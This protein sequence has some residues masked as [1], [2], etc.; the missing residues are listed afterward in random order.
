MSSRAAT[1]LAKDSWNLSATISISGSS[2]S[3]LPLLLS[4]E[5]FVYLVLLSQQLCLLAFTRHAIESSN[6]LF[7]FVAARHHHKRSS[8]SRSDKLSMRR[9]TLSSLCR[10]LSFISSSPAITPCCNLNAVPDKI[11]PIK[12]NPINATRL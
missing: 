6:M 2:R 12:K 9:S 10:S 3:S 5:P 1:N 4:G 7:N 11:A 8:S